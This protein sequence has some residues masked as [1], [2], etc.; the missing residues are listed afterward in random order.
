M[1][2]CGAF[3]GFHFVVPF[4]G[5]ISGS[6][7]FLGCRGLGNSISSPQKPA[8]PYSETLSNQL[9]QEQNGAAPRLPGSATCF[10]HPNCSSTAQQGCRASWQPETDCTTPSSIPKARASWR[11]R[12][13]QSET[14]RGV[15]IQGKSLL[16]PVRFTWLF[17]VL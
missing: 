13:W 17:H 11:N 9:A 14:S 12:F 8:E 3:R 7:D 1:R 5:G 2:A 6:H 4:L 10:A 16:G 15:F